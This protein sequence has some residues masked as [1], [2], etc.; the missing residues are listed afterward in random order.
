MERDAVC[1]LG[2]GL[3]VGE[4]DLFRKD[5]TSVG[6]ENCSVLE[7]GLLPGSWLWVSFKVEI[8]RL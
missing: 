4:Q 7:G 2:P 1:V 5:G 3:G 6:L 8:L